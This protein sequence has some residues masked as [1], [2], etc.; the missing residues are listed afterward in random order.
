MLAIIKF[1]ESG[2]K[3]ETS[4]YDIG[5]SIDKYG[6]NVISYIR[7]IVSDNIKYYPKDKTESR[8]LKLAISLGE[9]RGCTV[10]KWKSIKELE[11]K[12]SKVLSEN[13]K[14]GKLHDTY[15][16]KYTSTSVDTEQ[17]RVLFNW[18]STIVK[19]HFKNKSEK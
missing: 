16:I 1:D 14:R 10:K 11:T 19:D 12:I 7:Q 8:D 15:G 2:D 17:N 3:T 6:P 4:I 9:K 18:I 5:Y 13:T